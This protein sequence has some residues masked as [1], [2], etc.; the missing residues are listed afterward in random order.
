MESSG[1]II[2][3]DLRYFAFTKRIVAEKNGIVWTEMRIVHL[4][5]T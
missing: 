2:D 5:V 4:K 1:G 3:S